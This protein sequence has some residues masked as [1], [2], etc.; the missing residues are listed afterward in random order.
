[1]S[2]ACAFIDWHAVHDISRC[3]TEPSN[4][5]LIIIISDCTVFMRYACVSKYV[6]YIFVF[7]SR[8]IKC[9]PRC[10]Y[11]SVQ[12]NTGILQQPS[13]HLLPVNSDGVNIYQNSSVSPHPQILSSCRSEIYRLKTMK[14]N[15]D[16]S[17]G[18]PC[19]FLMHA[20]KY[21]KQITF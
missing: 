18:C 7:S 17:V 3:L 4:I 19:T 6:R 12:T 2:A 9:L 10:F 5:N 8:V 21:F 11:I 1:M 20:S 14:Q 13:S 15:S 16:L